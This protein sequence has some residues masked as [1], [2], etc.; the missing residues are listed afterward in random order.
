MPPTPFIGISLFIHSCVILLHKIFHWVPRRKIVHRKTTISVRLL[1]ICVVVFVFWFV[2][3]SAV[4]LVYVGIRDT[5]SNFK[6]LS[7]IKLSLP[8]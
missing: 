4:V 7:E 3:I 1:S 2:V 6:L 8:K 5:H